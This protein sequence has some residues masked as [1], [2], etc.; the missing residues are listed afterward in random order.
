MYFQKKYIEKEK[1]DF[2]L[3][4]EQMED[5]MNYEKISELRSTA[6]EKL[7]YIN[8]INELTRRIE[9]EDNRL[10]GRKEEII[11]NLTE[12]RNKVIRMEEEFN[13]G[14]KEEIQNIV[15]LEEDDELK[16]LEDTYVKIY[17][18]IDILITSFTIYET[19]LKNEDATWT[20][21][22]KLISINIQHFGIECKIQK[23]GLI[24]L[25][26]L[27]NIIISQE[28]IENPNY[29]KI[30]FGDL[31]IEG[32]LL[33]IIFEMN[34]SLKKSDMRVKVWSERQVY[35]IVD[36]YTL[37]Y[38]Q[39]Q[40]LDV[41][42]TTIDLEEVSSYAKGSVYNYIQEGYQD[43][44]IE[45]NFTH[46]N[47]YLDV[48]LKCP[49]IIIPI[50]VFDYNNTKCILLSLGSLQLKSILPPRVDKNIDYELCKDENIMYD[51][52]RIG[53]LGIRM[54]TVENCI[55]KNNYV[56]KETLLLKDFDF[57]IE[58]KLLIQPKNPYFN[59]IIVNLMI[60]KLDFELNEFQ[61]LLLIEFLGNLTKKGNKLKYE[62][63]LLKRDERLNRL[64]NIKRAEEKRMLYLTETEKKE[65]EKERE[66]KIKKKQEEMEKK[67]KEENIKRAKIKQK[68]Q[69]W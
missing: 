26:T 25:L 24:A 67:K 23:V 15:E 44:V 19:V 61:I 13:K 11:Q 1:I 2:P 58:C 66:E 65:Q 46:T 32:K 64:K 53:L 14:H 51:I 6:L 31:T 16:G 62:M 36:S 38:I 29:N 57:S 41:L 50:D 43:K 17:A 8:K 48:S 68:K 18:L 60:P 59:N 63:L 20:L 21:K 56:G 40:I 47:L 12:E 34:P 39:N 55:E 35:I 42:A 52:Y 28:K 4:L 27:E 45:G 69:Y 3:A 22:D 30:F 54:A 9:R 37:Q 7:D 33:C 49:I 5:H 10:F